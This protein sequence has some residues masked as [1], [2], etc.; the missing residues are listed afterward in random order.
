MR[1]IFATIAALLGV[2]HKT[3][4]AALKLL[5]KQITKEFGTRTLLILLAQQRAHSLRNTLVNT[6]QKLPHSLRQVLALLLASMA[7]LLLFHFQKS[8]QILLLRLYLATS[9]CP[10]P[11]LL[12]LVQQTRAH[13]EAS[14]VTFAMVLQLFNQFKLTSANA[15][16]CSLLQML[17]AVILVHRLVLLA[18]FRIDVLYPL[19]LNNNKGGLKEIR[20]FHLSSRPLVQLLVVVVVV[21]IIITIRHHL[22]VVNNNNNAFQKF[23]N[24][25][26]EEQ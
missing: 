23:V 14:V 24:K 5:A 11:L 16:G 17:E 25:K 10:L 26:M 15:Q 9:S 2:N 4:M 7:I 8:L 1:T 19:D 21:T 6:A 13:S 22:L 3:K 18:K 20:L 12:V